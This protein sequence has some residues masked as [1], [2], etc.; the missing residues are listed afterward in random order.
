MSAYQLENAKSGD[1]VAIMHTN[2]GDIKI[3]LFKEKAPKTVENFVTHSENGYYNGIV[4]HRVIKDFM[5]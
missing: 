1:I 2:A 5:I 3:R 4:F